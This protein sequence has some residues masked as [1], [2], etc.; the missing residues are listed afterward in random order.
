MPGRTGFRLNDH[1]VERLQPILDRFKIDPDNY[2]RF[3]KRTRKLRSHGLVEC[4][5]AMQTVASDF[6][7]SSLKGQAAT[8][9]LFSPSEN[10]AQ[11]GACS[12]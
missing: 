1:Y 2:I 5:K 6:N 11:F 8:A 7:R 9:A 10:P 4:V 12:T 3:I